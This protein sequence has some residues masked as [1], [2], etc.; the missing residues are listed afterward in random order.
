MISLVSYSIPKIIKGPSLFKGVIPGWDYG[1][2]DKIAHCISM[3]T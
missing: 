1:T 3:I 2:A